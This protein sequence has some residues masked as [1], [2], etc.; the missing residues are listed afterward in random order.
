MKNCITIGEWWWWWWR[1]LEWSNRRSIKRSCN[2]AHCEPWRGWQAGWPF[3]FQS[4]E[5]ADGKMWRFYFYLQL[6]Q[7]SEDAYLIVFAQ[8]SSLFLFFFCFCRVGGSSDSDGHA[9]VVDLDFQCSLQTRRARKHNTNID[10]KRAR[11]TTNGTTY[12][13]VSII[14]FGRLCFFLK[15]LLRCN[16]CRVLSH[17][18][19]L[20]HN[21]NHGRQ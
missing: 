8:S 2:E 15:C 5:T 19:V 16:I 6:H 17:G 20:L 3:A 12:K 7:L 13:D 14:V 11:T 1:L 4:R 10:W 18:E 9:K 21:T